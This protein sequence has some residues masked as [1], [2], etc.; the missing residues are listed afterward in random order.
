M[1]E[2]ERLCGLLDRDRQ[3]NV[4]ALKNTMER[5]RSIFAGL[6]L[7]YSFLQEGYP[8]E[9]WQQVRIEKGAYGKPHI[10][11]YPDFHYSLSHSGEWVVC[12]ADTGP[13]GAD[14]QE[15]R[16]F[17]L[18][19]AERFY[20]QDEYDR[21]LGT[22]ESGQI[23]EFYSMW[24]AKESAVKQ[25]GRGIGAGIS[26]YVTAGDYRYIHDEIQDKKI[27]I[28]LYD[29]LEGYIA[30]VCSETGAFPKRPELIDVVERLRK[31]HGYRDA[32]GK[33]KKY[34]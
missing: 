1:A 9:E 19:V 25:N 26:R 30:C 22:G 27:N 13:V 16:P 29:E 18:Q 33:W 14:I 21:L 6:L 5:Q 10:K 31:E 28:R 11:G 4:S 7:R 20:S 17:R 8:V 24:T 32:K 3:R 34:R 12:A 15:M 23:K 2:A